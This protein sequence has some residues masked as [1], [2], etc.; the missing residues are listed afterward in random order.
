VRVTAAG[1]TD[2]GVHADGQVISFDTSSTI[3]PHGLHRVLNSS[4]PEDV[5]VNTSAEV[6]A[7][8][9]ARRS[10]RR[11]WYRYALWRGHAPSPEWHGRALA[12]SDALD[13]CAM[14][15]ASTSLIGSHDFASFAT[16]HVGTTQR[17]LFAADW[18]QVNPTLLLFEVCATGF[19]KHMVRGVVGSLLWVGGGRWSPTEFERALKATDRRAAGPNAPAHGLTLHRIDY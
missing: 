14:R 13:L 4:L 3:T 9:D 5:W 19:L 12:H 15:E 7:G 18:R 8:F 10:A 2:A 11:R 1:R 17:T 6:P 16:Q